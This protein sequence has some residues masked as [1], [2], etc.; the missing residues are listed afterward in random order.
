LKLTI[1]R[2]AGDIFD[3]RITKT[4]EFTSAAP[5][6]SVFPLWAAYGIPMHLVRWIMPGDESPSPILVFY[7][8]RILFFLISFVLGMGVISYLLWREKEWLIVDGGWVGGVI[9]T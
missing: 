5:I 7:S 9:E 6:R 8:L 1:L 2:T 4:W 3:W